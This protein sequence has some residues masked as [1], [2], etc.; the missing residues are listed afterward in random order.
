[1]RHPI[2]VGLGSSAASPRWLKGALAILQARLGVLS[3]SR[4]YRSEPAGGVAQQ[5]FWNAAVLVV[6][7]PHKVL[8]TALEIEADLGRRRGP[9]WGDRRVDLDLLWAPTV[10]IETPRLRLPH[11]RL[12]ERD[13]ALAPLLE[14]APFARDPRSGV[15]LSELPPC[16]P[17]AIAV[18]TLGQRGRD[19]LSMALARGHGPAY[20]RPREPVVGDPVEGES[21]ARQPS[22]RRGSVPMKFFIDT[23]NLDEIRRA[24][25]WGIVD[26]VT[27]NPAL[28]AKEGRDFVE[29]IAEICTLIDGP[30]SAEVVAEDAEEMVKQGKLLA[31]IHDNVVVK[32]PLTQEGIVATSQLS[33]LGIK[34]NVTLCF[35]PIQALVAAKAGATY[36]SPFIGRIDDVGRDGMVMIQDMVEIYGNYPALNT[37]ILAASIRHPQHVLQAA[38]A[39]ADVATIPFGVMNKLFGH[40]LTDSGNAKFNK[41]WEG[42]PN[43]DIVS[44][45][46]AW[47]EKNER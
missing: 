36:I 38:L 19:A 41:A 18:G 7:D 17:R 4:L 28:I 31:R 42:V 30:V 33:A 35:Q 25:R 32:V 5:W 8:D 34:T 29:T 27:T 20:L 9:R 47:L 45:V 26:G 43:R 15:R 12:H 6:G 23:A 2:V 22:P 21:I 40:P 13:F 24:A 3:H 37:Q 46:S 16:L 44:Q 14:I 1:M 39:G 11:P 10:V